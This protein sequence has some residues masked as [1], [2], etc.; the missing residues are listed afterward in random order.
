[1]NKQVNS[2]RLLTKIGPKMKF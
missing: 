2:I 1:M